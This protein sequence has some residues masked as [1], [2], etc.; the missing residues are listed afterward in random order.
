M[1]LCRIGDGGRH[2]IEYRLKA[3]TDRGE[4]IIESLQEKQQTLGCDCGPNET[5]LVEITELPDQRIDAI[6][7][8]PRAVAEPGDWRPFAVVE[9]MYG[10]RFDKG[11]TAK[12][13]HESLGE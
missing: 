1:K 12:H 2:L 4:S 5:C 8:K 6:V 13:I 3:L 7:T 9:G 11:T 10:R